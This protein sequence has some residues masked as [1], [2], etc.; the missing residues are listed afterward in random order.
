MNSP[1]P[2][3]RMCQ[4]NCGGRLAAR[5]AGDWLAS[6][7]AALNRP[8]PQDIILFTESHLSAGQE[9]PALAGYCFWL[10]SRP[11][12]R[13]R[14]GLVLY[15]RTCLASQARQLTCDWRHGLLA[16]HL[17]SVDLVVACRYFAPHSSPLYVRGVLHPGPIEQWCS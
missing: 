9:P 13:Q 14:G 15:V 3:L 8:G 17:A 1:H 10:C 12:A 4:L 7:V 2:G 6:V 11:G 16:I 5:D